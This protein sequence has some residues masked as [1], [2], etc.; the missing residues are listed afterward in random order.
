VRLAL[1]PPGQRI[2]VDAARVRALSLDPAAV[3]RAAA[4]VDGGLVVATPGGPVRVVIAA[5]PSAEA[6]L[7][8]AVGRLPG[9]EAIRL[10]DVARATVGVTERHDRVAGRE[11]E[12]IV[13]R[14]DVGARRA[15][16]DELARRIDE[17]QRRAG[18]AGGVA[19]IERAADLALFDAVCP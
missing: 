16:L 8:A 17:W 13:L 2:V 7:A 10:F 19:R 6:A 11:A 14:F 4:V 18:S 1:P 9:G 5:A 15:A 3:A 12:R